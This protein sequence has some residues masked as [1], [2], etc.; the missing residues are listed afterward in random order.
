[1]FILI[2]EAFNP[3]N[4]KAQMRD[5]YLGLPDAAGDDHRPLEPVYE[6]V[7]LR[8]LLLRT[9]KLFI[10]SGRAQA[11]GAGAKRHGLVDDGLLTTFLVCWKLEYHAAQN[12][13]KN[14]MISCGAHD[15]NRIL[16]P[17]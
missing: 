16:A 2:L 9:K 14:G 4:M 8:G 13:G 7:S 12:P 3:K 11:Q 6:T 17:S 15:S 5:L 1:M 10:L